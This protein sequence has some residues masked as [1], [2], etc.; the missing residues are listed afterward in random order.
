MAEDAWN[1]RNSEKV[2]MAYTKSV[3]GEIE[4]SS[5]EGVKRYT[6]V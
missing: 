6:N 4:Q 5:L 2:S 3:F 1:S